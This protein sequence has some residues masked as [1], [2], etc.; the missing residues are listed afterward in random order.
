MGYKLQFKLYDGEKHLFIF[1]RK[2]DIDRLVF[3]KRRE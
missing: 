2:L 1:I 3:L